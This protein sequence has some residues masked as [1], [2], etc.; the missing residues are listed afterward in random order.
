MSKTPLTVDEIR[1]RVEA[2][3]PNIK[4]LLA[5]LVS[6]ESLAFPGYDPQP[7]I[8]C[9]KATLEAVR[10]AGFDNAEL[11]KVGP[12][13]DCVWATH[14]VSDE[15]PTVLLYSHY[16][17]QPAPKEEQGWETDP[18]VLTEKADGRLY[19]RGAADDKSGIVGHLGAIKALGGLDAIKNV[20]LKLCIEGE[21]EA[22]GHLD[23]FIRAEPERFKADI[24]IIA[25]SGNLKVGEPVLQNSLRGA[26]VLDVEVKTIKQELHSG[27]FGG[28]TPDAFLAAARLVDS[29][30]DEQGNT[31]IE[32]IKEGIWEGAEYPEE[33]FRDQI[34]LYEGV[35]IIGSDSIATQLW[36][37]PSLTVT[38]IDMQ[39]VDR[40][41]NV[42]IPSVKLR[43]GLRIPPQN[44][45][46]EAIQ[47]LKAQI[48]KNAPFG[49]Q[50]N[51]TYEFGAPG[52]YKELEGAFAEI[53][54]D[55]MTEAFGHPTT[56]IGCGASIPLVYELSQAWPDATVLILGATDLE[57]SRIHGG[58]ESVHIQELKDSI[59][60]E[61]L[62]ISRF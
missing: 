4:E 18:F 29:L 30:Y 17:I 26:I 43:F 58:N 22:M 50:I 3:F 9:G 15:L 36:A 55:A 44:T 38:G 7:N 47:A 25:D 34:G 61:A 28:A 33:M 14:Q 52:F 19:G 37:K 53:A 5:H 51:F 40:A 60:S 12:G 49:A 11:I 21:E 8:D 32:G 56:S 16:D 62:M 46:E 23:S 31:K 6:F 35:E 1:A 59:V 39:S 10:S 54:A 57:N 48:K 24:F 13:F 45:Y 20:N 2:D 41:S 42:I 27:L